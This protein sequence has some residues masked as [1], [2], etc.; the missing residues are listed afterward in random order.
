MIEFT[1]VGGD[2]R[3]KQSAILF[4]EAGSLVR[5][6]GLKDMEKHKNIR[7]YRELRP[8]LLA[9]MNCLLDASLMAMKKYKSNL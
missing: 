3:Y 6:F 4:V 7:S 1:F 9:D 2:N 5:I 8:E